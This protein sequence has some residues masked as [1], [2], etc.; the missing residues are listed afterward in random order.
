M[1]GYGSGRRYDKKNTV[2]DCRSLDPADLRRFGILR[3]GA[4]QS[5]GLT[6]TNAAGEERASVGYE[7]QTEA[8]A[9]WFRLHYTVRGDTPVDYRV[10]LDTTPVHFGGERWWFL[11]P[12]VGCGRRVRKLYL[13]PGGT[14]FA[15]RHCYNLTYES[16]QTHDPRMS[17][18][19][20]RP[21]AALA[22]LN[23]RDESRKFLAMRA[24]LA[25]LKT[26][27]ERRRRSDRWLRRG[28]NRA[29]PF[30]SPHLK[31]NE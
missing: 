30:S 8:G 6:W 10:Q 7:L 1:G 11:C 12:A 13:A 19:L 2:E 28:A 23:G 15:C 3:R 22:A 25:G 20:N 31:N 14:Y 18:F 5:G 9:A 26:A 16:A 29:G 4:W 17:F 21:E 24:V 27:R